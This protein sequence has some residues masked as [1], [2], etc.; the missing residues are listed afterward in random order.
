MGGGVS[1]GI[2][3]IGGTRLAAS[4]SERVSL[5]DMRVPTSVRG[6]SL[7]VMRLADSG[8]EG[9]L[10]FALN[11]GPDHTVYNSVHYVVYCSLQSSGHPWILAMTVL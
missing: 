5:G 3:S 1:I 7:G 11:T 9:V 10:R 2:T 6:S 8:S 4:I